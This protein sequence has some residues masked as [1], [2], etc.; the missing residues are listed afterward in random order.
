MPSLMLLEHVFGSWAMMS[1]PMPWK[2]R[3]AMP[4]GCRMSSSRPSMMTSWSVWA[5]QRRPIR[6]AGRPPL[7]QWDDDAHSR[8][9]IQ[10]IRKASARRIIAVWLMPFLRSPGWPASR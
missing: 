3:L 5:M 2:R 6:M 8:P 1:F 4:S 7:V 10:P 9:P